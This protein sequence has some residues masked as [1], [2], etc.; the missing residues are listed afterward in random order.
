MEVGTLKISKKKH[1]YSQ[2]VVQS[3]EMTKENCKE[4]IIRNR[5]TTS[6]K[7]NQLAAKT[8]IV[9]RIYQHDELFLQWQ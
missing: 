7:S 8:G 1:K 2:F 3:K 5:A 6:K 9:I 4:K